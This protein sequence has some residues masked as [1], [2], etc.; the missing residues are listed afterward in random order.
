MYVFAYFNIY[1][2]Y[3]V[4]FLHM[5]GRFFGFLF[6]FKR[7]WLSYWWLEYPW[8][9]LDSEL[10]H[11]HCNSTKRE[12][13]ILFVGITYY[14]NLLG[15]IFWG[16]TLNF[17]LV[18]SLNFSPEG[19]NGLLEF[20]KEWKIGYYVFDFFIFRP[21]NNSSVL[22]P[23]HKPCFFMCLMFISLNLVN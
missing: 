4:D 3:A 5:S 20:C 21:W 9:W 12:A 17:S 1:L 23:S 19:W 7:K 6:T 10:C 2:T 22:R 14:Q 15:S 18:K 11:L 8:L 16:K 13:Y